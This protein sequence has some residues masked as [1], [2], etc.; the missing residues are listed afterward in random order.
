MMMIRITTSVTSSL[1]WKRAGSTT[2]SS[3]EQTSA[4]P[5][6]FDVEDCVESKTRLALPVTPPSPPKSIILLTTPQSA[7]VL[8]K[9]DLG[10][11]S[12]NGACDVFAAAVD[13][14]PGAPPS[15]DGGATGRTQGY[16]WLI[17]SQSIRITI[18]PTAAAGTTP[19]K[20]LSFGLRSKKFTLPLANTLFH[21]GSRTTIVHIPAKVNEIPVTIEAAEG[22]C[23]KEVEEFAHAQQDIKEAWEE[24]GELMKLVGR[25]SGIV[26]PAKDQEKDCV[27]IALPPTHLP[28]DTEVDAHLPLKQLTFPRRIEAGMGNILKQT[29]S[30]T[31]TPQGASRELEE[32]VLDYISSPSTPSLSR[33]LSIFAR[34]TPH[35]SVAHENLFTAPGARIHRVLSGGGGWGSK[36]GLLSLDPQSETQVE[37]FAKNFESGEGI[38]KVGEYVQ[39]FVAERGCGGGGAWRGVVFG[40]VPRVEELADELGG[41]EEEVVI[42]GLFG[43]ASEEG[44]W[45]GDRK[46]DVPGGVVS[47]PVTE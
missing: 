41:K 21:T 11:L 45:I 28:A 16:S 30:E 2:V 38:V 40:C 27:D 1:G 39:F 15:T 43:G 23:P 33:K 17:T 24:L 22:V 18:P 9:E 6:V 12:D 20:S 3:S 25:R 14:L 10:F 37:V 8:T 4:S 42:D 44:V 36:A 32:A 47:V 26:P 31:G 7:G 46:M 13:S 19:A 5:W 34:L 35:S 29:S